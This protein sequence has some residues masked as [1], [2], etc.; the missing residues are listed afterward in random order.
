MSISQM[1]QLQRLLALYRAELEKISP[2][3]P[4]EIRALNIERHL[5]ELANYKGK[6]LLR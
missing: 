3:H 1:R 2:I 6:T 5:E 4:M